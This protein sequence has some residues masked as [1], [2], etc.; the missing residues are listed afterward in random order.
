MK[1]ISRGDRARLRR[2][3]ALAAMATGIIV[4]AACGNGA[5]PRA[6]LFWADGIGVIG[7]ADLNGTGVSE[8]FI[9]GASEPVGI[10]VSSRYI[11]WA[12]NATGTIGRANLDGT[13][14]N[15][16]F[17]TGATG[18]TDLAV[19]SGY[20]YWTNPDSGTIGR[21]D[22]D[23]TRVNQRIVTVQAGRPLGVT[24]IPGS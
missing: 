18:P 24:L 9:T 21:A 16:H 11:Y 15:Q 12:N 19:G 17:I 8:R 13:G 6:Y 4:L 7:R 3:F 10:A 14:V 20:I 22:L 23:G 5:S 1:E 2:R